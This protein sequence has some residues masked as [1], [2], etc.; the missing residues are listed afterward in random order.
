MRYGKQ[1]AKEPKADLNQLNN[2]KVTNS[3]IDKVENLLSTQHGTVSSPESL[4][5]KVMEE[6]ADSTIPK[7]EKAKQCKHEIFKDDDMIND[8]I[9]RRSKAKENSDEKKSLTK[10]LKTRVKELR[11]EKLQKEADE[12]TLH[13]VRKDTEKMFKEFFKDNYAFK[14][15]KSNE[16][17]D[18][19][20]LKEHFE[21][22]FQLPQKLVMP[23]EL[24]EIPEYP[25]MIEDISMWNNI[26][27]CS[28]TTKNRFGDEKVLMPCQKAT[29]Q[30]NSTKTKNHISEFTDKKCSPLRGRSHY[31]SHQYKYK[32]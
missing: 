4:L 5:I 11:N 14:S 1:A 32:D 25:T 18:P 22:H 24:V 17:R 19:K 27:R 30:E 15:H 8:L 16:T 29:E 6:A 31:L 23:D 13:A 3:Y 9:E 12:I 26:I 20:K 28:N 2:G 7:K 21:K 10:A